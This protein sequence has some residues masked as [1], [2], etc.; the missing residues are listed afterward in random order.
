M[1]PVKDCYVRPNKYS[2]A[3]IS[4]HNGDEFNRNFTCAKIVFQ[5]CLEMIDTICYQLTRRGICPTQ[6]RRTSWRQQLKCGALSRRKSQASVAVT[7]GHS[8]AL[9]ALAFN[10][11]V[12]TKWNG[13]PRS[14]VRSSR[15]L[16]I[17]G[18]FVVAAGNLDSFLG[19][20]AS[21]RKALRSCVLSVR[22][23]SVCSQVPARLPL[24]VR[25]WSLIMGG[26]TFMDIRTSRNSKFG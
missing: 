20:F 2:N 22:F 5:A 6:W 9:S 23:L 17:C 25:P 18:V 14:S 16:P 11:T 12:C 1:N 4:R 26:G 15:L 3:E 13:A 21:S 10:N 19:A 8:L 7:D 24:D